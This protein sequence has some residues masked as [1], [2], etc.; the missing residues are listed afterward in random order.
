MQSRISL[1]TS[2]RPALV[3]AA[4]C[5]STAAGASTITQNTSWTIDR[6]G[7]ST[8]YRDAHGDR[9]RGYRGSLERREARGA[10]G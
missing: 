7:T 4:L 6:S 1:R 2:L 10:L 9:S 3:V 8:V 5:V